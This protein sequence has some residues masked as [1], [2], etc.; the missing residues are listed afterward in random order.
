MITLAA[1]EEIP[2]LCKCSLT[3]GRGAMTSVCREGVQH[4]GL[5][6]GA[7]CSF[8]WVL[9]VVPVSASLLAM[10][11]KLELARRGRQEVLLLDLGV[12]FG[13]FS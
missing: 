4:W 2:W 6:G 3:N 7:V 12:S 5:G 13:G 8:C 9:L 1:D 10:A 11:T